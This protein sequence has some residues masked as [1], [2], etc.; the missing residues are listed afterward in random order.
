[1]ETFTI[2]YQLVQSIID[3]VFSPHPP[4]PS[5]CRPPVYGKKVA[6]IGAG[7]T[8]VSSA[9]HCIGNGVDVTIFEAR[10]KEHGLGGIWS[11]WPKGAFIAQLLTSN[12]EDQCYLVT[13]SS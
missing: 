5:T 7:L 8:G 10:S 12:A 2:L 3:W 4:P 11:V 1:M 13:A 9:A 6:V